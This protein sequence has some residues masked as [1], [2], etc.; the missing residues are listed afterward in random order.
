MD[1]PNFNH[2]FYFWTVARE[3]SIA[4]AS[5]SLLLAPP[6]ISAQVR[7]LERSL[8]VK[9]F[10]RSGRGL[11]LTDAGR[12]A[13]RY[14]DDMFT[15]GRDLLE[16]LEG[17]PTGRPLR[18]VVGVADN[19]PKLITYR[20]IKP[21]LGLP[22]PVQLVCHEGRVE[23]LL[24][25]LAVH[26]L[27]VVLSDAPVGPD[28]RVRAYNHQLGECGVTIFGTA[29]MARALRRGF[30]RSLDRAPFLLPSS[31]TALRRSLDG[32][33][34]AQGIR[35]AIKGE[36]D[37]SALMKVFGQSGEGLF[38]APSAVEG[39]VRKQYR[40]HVVGRVESVRERFYA[41]SVERRLKHPAVVA[42]SEAAR[43]GLFS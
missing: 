30:P 13:F 6:T 8:G 41:I 12:T 24:A 34:D 7:A 1:W 32:W 36:L 39:D 3:G 26:G 23:R 4:R 2:L 37:D 28:V 22:E 16:A 20:L 9:L 40:V 38:P 43:Q 10:T 31:A 25:E 17:R 35:P 29:E 18:L 21:A 11:A 5:E 33:F 27:D 14:A 19:L 15:T 42:I